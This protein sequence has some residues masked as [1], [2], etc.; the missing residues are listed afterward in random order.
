MQAAEGQRQQRHPR[1]PQRKAGADVAQ[2]M[3]AEVQARQT[4]SRDQRRCARVK[5]QPGM[6]TKASTQQERQKAVKD[7]RR[8][9]VAAGKRKLFDTAIDNAGALA[10]Q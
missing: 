1:K 2:P 3:H 4:N 9:G 6:V 7:H 8:G 10:R 5:G